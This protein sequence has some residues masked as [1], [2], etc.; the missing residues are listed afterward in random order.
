M[1]ASKTVASQRLGTEEWDEVE[2]RLEQ[3]MKIAMMRMK[4]RMMI[5]GRELNWLDWRTRDGEN[6]IVERWGSARE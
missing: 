6:S 1:E 5:L 3:K 4:K 2:A